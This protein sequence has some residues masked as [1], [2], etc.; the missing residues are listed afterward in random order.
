M[1]EPRGSQSGSLAPLAW[2]AGAAR[3]GA[4]SAIGR[5]A[6]PGPRL[7][8]QAA[9]WGAAGRAARGREAP[10]RPASTCQAQRSPPFARVAAQGGRAFLFRPSHI[11]RR[12]R[13]PPLAR[14]GPAVCDVAGP[15]PWL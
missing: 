12:Q 15:A 5:A 10:G 14:G 11:P 8:R 3:A 4:R 7:A 1:D 6:R 2:S 9:G 13:A